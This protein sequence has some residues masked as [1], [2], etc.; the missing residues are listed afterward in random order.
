MCVAPCVICVTQEVEA[1]KLCR[2]LELKDHVPCQMQRLTKYPMLIEN[3]LKYTHS[4]KYIHDDDDYDDDI[5][6]QTQHLTKYPMLVE[7]LLKY[8]HS[9]KYIH[10][11]DDDRP[12]QTQHL[13]KYPML[14]ENLL[15]HVHTRRYIYTCSSGCCGFNRRKDSSSSCDDNDREIGSFDLALTSVHWGLTPAPRTLSWQRGNMRNRHQHSTTIADLPTCC[16]VG[17]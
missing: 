14:V 17:P 13:T 16:L 1:D 2:K 11:D 8:T 5:P 4:S 12:C 9:S 6:C 3:L 15:K 10:D 7:N